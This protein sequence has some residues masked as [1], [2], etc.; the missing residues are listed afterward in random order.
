MATF[1]EDF[2]RMRQEFDQSQDDRQRLFGHTREQ[3][4]QM[5]CGVREQLAGFQQEFQQMRG[6]I[7]EAADRVRTGLREFGTDLKGGGRVFRKKSKP[8]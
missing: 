3:V 6:D 8:R 2:T 4:E 7:A 5:A 1:T